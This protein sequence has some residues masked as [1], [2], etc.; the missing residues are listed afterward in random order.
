MRGWILF[1]LLALTILGGC[2]TI[3]KS[4]DSLIESRSVLQEKQV[5][6]EEGARS[7]RP[8]GGD[9]GWAF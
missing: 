7:V 9:A 1:F 5:A 6:S 8:S 2:T 3:R 4:L